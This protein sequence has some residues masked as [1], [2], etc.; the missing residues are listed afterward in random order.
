MAMHRAPK[1]WLAR[2]LLAAAAIT[3]AP[4]AWASPSFPGEIQERLRMS[5]A[6]PCTLCHRDS[7]GGLGTADTAFA[8]QM[9]ANGLTAGDAARIG[10]ALDAIEASAAD[11]DGDGIGDVAELRDERDPN[12][13]GAGVVCGPSYGCGA[14]VAPRSTMD[15]IALAAA[16]AVALGLCAAARRRT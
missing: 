14:H 9:V 8:D 1:N 4:A 2:W 16:L 11:S 15:P 12:I 5:C 6:P 7:T 3:S 13:A 10:P